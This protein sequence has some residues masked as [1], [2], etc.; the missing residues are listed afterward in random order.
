MRARRVFKIR[1]QWDTGVRDKDF[2]SQAE[3]LKEQICACAVA[4]GTCTRRH[5][6]VA[7]PYLHKFSSETRHPLAAASIGRSKPA[8]AQNIP[9]A[10]RNMST[11]NCVN[12]DQPQSS[13][14]V[15]ILATEDAPAIELHLNTIAHQK[16]P[17][18]KRLRMQLGCI[19]D[20]LRESVAERDRF[21]VA[22]P[23]SSFKYS[24]KAGSYD[25]NGR[26]GCAD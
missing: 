20:S 12:V 19:Y 18:C 17:Q 9:G 2:Q 1:C 11:G 14:I 10:P 3:R 22:I 5:L 26:E 7:V 23:S 15:S 4:V 8:C 24:L 6:V 25:S 21:S 13:K 16:K